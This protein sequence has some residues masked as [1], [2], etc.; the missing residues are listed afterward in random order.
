MD[1]EQ[2]A[3]SR[4]AAQS[5][6]GKRQLNEETRPRKARSRG[7]G[8]RP[9]DAFP[10]GANQKSVMDC[11]AFARNKVI[12][13]TGLSV[14]TVQKST[15]RDRASPCIPPKIDRI[16]SVIVEIEPSL[17]IKNTLQRGEKDTSGSRGHFRFL[18]SRKPRDDD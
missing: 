3:G 13:M 14:K 18:W 7:K 17:Y 6:S 8:A 2:G 1:V 10:Q 11:F 16:H 9:G 4:E 12:A 5:R 15:G